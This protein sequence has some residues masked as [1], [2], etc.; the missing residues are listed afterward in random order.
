MRASTFTNAAFALLGLGSVLYGALAAPTPRSASDRLV[1][2]K[3]VP[4]LVAMGYTITEGSISVFGLKTYVITK[5]AAPDFKNS[6]AVK[7]SSGRVEI[8]KVDND[9]DSGDTA[10]LSDQVMYLFNKKGG[11]DPEDLKEIYFES[12]YEKTTQPAIAEAFKTLGLGSD[13][14]TFTV[15]SDDDD[16]KETVFNSL[17]GTPFGQMFGRFESDYD[18]EECNQIDITGGPGAPNM[19]LKLN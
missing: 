19:L 5:A 18:T 9:K 7:A 8:R 13:V 4:D 16:E 3:D 2:R 14:F 11:K 15:N 17:L 12:I 6:F 10:Y 1:A